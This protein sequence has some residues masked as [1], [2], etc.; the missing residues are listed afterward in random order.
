MCEDP[1]SSEAINK[2]IVREVPFSEVQTTELRPGDRITGVNNFKDLDAFVDSLSLKAGARMPYSQL[3]ALTFNSPQYDPRLSYSA[4]PRMD[5]LLS[6]QFRRQ[7]GKRKY[8]G[9][10]RNFG[11]VMLPSDSRRWQKEYLLYVAG[12]MDSTGGGVIG[13]IQRM[14]SIYSSGGIPSVDST[15]I[16][17]KTLAADIEALKIKAEQG[18]ITAYRLAL[19]NIVQGGLPGLGKRR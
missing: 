7:G 4:T 18:Y 6:E 9:T 13:Q 3:L 1:I 10:I 19:E 14:V 15:E 17:T 5:I 11:I 2:E 8:N 12:Y 16:D